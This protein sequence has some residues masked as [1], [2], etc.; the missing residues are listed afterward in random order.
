MWN[1]FQTSLF[2]RR[3][4]FVP[5]LRGTLLQYIFDSR[6]IAKLIEESS[7]LIIFA[8]YF[9]FF[10]VNNKSPNGS[11]MNYP[12]WSKTLSIHYWPTGDIR[13]YHFLTHYHRFI[14]TEV[15]KWKLLF[16]PVWL[17]NFQQFFNDFF[18]QVFLIHLLTQKNS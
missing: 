14:N 4:W 6:S 13:C 7:K 3:I 17:C 18:T 12:F 1:G 10:F 16:H 2:Q 11:R 8:T 15:S 5:D 9:N